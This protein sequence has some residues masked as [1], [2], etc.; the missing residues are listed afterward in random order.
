MFDEP[1]PVRDDET[2]NEDENRI[3]DEPVSDTGYAPPTDTNVTPEEPP[4][5]EVTPEEPP[6]E[7]PPAEEPPAEELPEVVLEE[8]TERNVPVGFSISDLLNEGDADERE[9][10]QV[11]LP[12]ELPI[13]PLKDTVVY[14]SSV[15]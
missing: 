1:P 9:E 4:A 10:E 3:V 2:T 12:D 5:E 14:P 7:E 13:L 15:S 8:S 11:E 6:A